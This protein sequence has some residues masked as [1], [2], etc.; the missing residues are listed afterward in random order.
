MH[1]SRSDSVII[2]V[3]IDDAERTS[4]CVERDDFHAI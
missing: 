4:A 1:D 2:A 3:G